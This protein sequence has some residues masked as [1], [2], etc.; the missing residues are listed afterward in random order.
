MRPAFQ[1]GGQSGYREKCI[2]G[3]KVAPTPTAIP[4]KGTLVRGNTALMER[5]SRNQESQPITSASP[6]C[7]RVQWVTYTLACIY[8]IFLQCHLG[9]TVVMMLSA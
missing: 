1:A 4:E 2:D 7:T 8:G 3:I 9:G 6:Q 5:S